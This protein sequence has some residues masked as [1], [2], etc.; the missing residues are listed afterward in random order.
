MCSTNKF[1][2]LISGKDAPGAGVGFLAMVA[3]AAF[4]LFLETR[5]SGG[6]ASAL[7]A[8][9]VSGTHVRIAT[10]DTH[11]WLER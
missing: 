11:L 1:V 3:I 5:R 6:F 4:A 7:R 10:V 9:W 2:S 8:W